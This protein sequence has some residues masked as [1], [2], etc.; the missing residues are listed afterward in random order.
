V[1]PASAPAAPGALVQVD[2]ARRFQTISG[3]QA[4]G[5][6]FGECVAWPRY[7]SAVQDRLVSEMGITRLTVPLRTGS[8]NDRDYYGLWNAGLISDSVYRASWHRPVND[9]AD[10]LVTDTSR[11]HFGFL[12]DKMTN[13]VLPLRARVMARGERFYLVL[14]VVDFLGANQTRPLDIV[15]SP[16][17][18]A[19]LMTMAFVHLRRRFGFVPDALE[20]LLEPETTIGAAQS[21]G[22]DLGRALAAA[23]A[24][25][26]AR[27]FA[28]EF[29]APSTAKAGNAP[30]YFDGAVSAGGK[31]DWITYHRYNLPPTVA[32]LQA[33]AARATGGVRSA[34]LEHIG[35]GI[36]DLLADLTLAN[37]SAWM[38]FSGAFCGTKDNPA[39]P[40]VYYQ[41][42]QSDPSNPRINI[43]NHAK[44]LRQVFAHVREGAVRVGAVSGDSTLTPAAFV[45]AT[46]A[47]VVVV[48]T[49][50]AKAFTV[51]GLPAGTYTVTH[52]LDGGAYNVSQPTIT[53]PDGRDVV[54]D[55]P[56]KGALTIAGAQT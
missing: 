40:G 2:L 49:S 50:G 36:D 26:A 9:N 46:G 47:A 17:E 44:L 48:R 10:P 4:G 20:I 53:K 54:L 24:R 37:V 25:L 32:D 21:F 8:E 6:G 23:K 51:R 55:I 31:P 29:L 34:M 1:A 52:A 27:G 22:P 16:A 12:D 39:N 45:N 33:I 15:K 7:A 43:T 28:P 35:S 41:V 56:G 5:Q 14:T 38:Q 18:Y 11:F 19:E 3:W 30:V 13:E 42:N